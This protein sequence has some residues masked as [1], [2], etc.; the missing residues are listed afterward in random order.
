M[1]IAGAAWDR[2]RT[3]R[4]R[5]LGNADFQRLASALPLANTISRRAFPASLRSAR[6]FQ[7]FAG[8]VRLREPRVDRHAGQGPKRAEDIARAIAWPDDRVLILLRAAASLKIFDVTSTGAY[9]LGIHG[10]AMAGNPWIAKFVVHHHL[11]YADLADPLA[12]LRG[13]VPETP[14][15]GFWSYAGKPDAKRQVEMPRITR[16]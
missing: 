6:R 9:D 5:L 14:L 16:L 11:L 13:D 3:F 2:W 4:N 10:A 7:L 12:L 8:A 15:R 1:T